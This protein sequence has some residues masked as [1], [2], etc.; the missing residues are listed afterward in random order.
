MVKNRQYVLNDA[1]TGERIK[2]AD[3]LED[4]FSPGRIILMSMC[5]Q[6]RQSVYQFCP[7]CRTSFS[8]SGTTSSETKW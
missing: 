4:H 8:D 1:H 2:L 7:G 5:Y 6:D 3:P